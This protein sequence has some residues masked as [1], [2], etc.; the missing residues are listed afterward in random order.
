MRRAAWVVLA[1]L[2]FAAGFACSGETT[3]CYDCD[4]G[5]GPFS[6]E[7]VVSRSDRAP[8]VGAKVSVWSGGL[9]ISGTADGQPFSAT[10][11]DQ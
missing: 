10:Y 8:L 2:G 9:S 7:G 5:D 1:A 4:C 6:L 3:P 11:R